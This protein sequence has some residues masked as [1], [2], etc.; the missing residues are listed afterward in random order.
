MNG[1]VITSTPHTPGK[2]VTHADCPLCGMTNYF[3]GVHLN[4]EIKCFY[5]EQFIFVES[6]R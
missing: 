1:I 4:E 5:C 3:S 6:S 2:L